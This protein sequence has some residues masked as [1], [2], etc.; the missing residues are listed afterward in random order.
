MF[1]LPKCRN[2]LTNTPRYYLL[3]VAALLYLHC[4]WDEEIS[5]QPLLS[6]HISAVFQYG[7]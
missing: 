4:T 5:I 6:G 1:I 2:H 3:A 7:N